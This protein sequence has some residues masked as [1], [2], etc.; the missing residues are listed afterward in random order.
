M[1]AVKAGAKAFRFLEE[2]E[3]LEELEWALARRSAPVLPSQVSRQKDL[4][5]LHEA[6]LQGSRNQKKVH[7]QR[8]EVATSTSRKYH[9]R[10]QGCQDSGPKGVGRWL[11]SDILR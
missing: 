3:H 4:E 10:S 9:P 8:E 6:C 11:S 7:F 1:E 2:R 5:V